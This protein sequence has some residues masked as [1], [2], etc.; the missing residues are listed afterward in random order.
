M[1]NK[2]LILILILSLLVTAC[3]SA[4]QAATATQE[5]I[6]TVIADDTIIA[7]GRVEPLQYAEIAFSTSGVVS[8]VLVKTGEQVKKGQPLIRLGDESETNYAAAQLELVTAQQ[9]LNDLLN[10]SSSDLAQIVIDLK[11]AQE[12]YDK[13]DDYLHYLQDSKK[14]PQTETRTYLI[15]TWKGYEYR[16]KTKSFKGPA[17]QDWIIEAENDLALKKARLV[18]VQRAYDRTKDGADADQLALLEAELN[19]ANAQV[20]AFSV[21][22]PFDGVVADLNAKVGGSINAGEIAV[23]VA[24]FSNWLVKTTDLTE[25]DVVELTEAQLVVVT[26]DAIPD[27]RL[28]GTVLSIGQR[29]TE[30]QGDVVYEVTVLLTDT[31][32]AMRWGMTSE[33]KFERGAQG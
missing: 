26:L 24:D 11:D 2:I 10:S 23:T 4:G 30:N 14:V 33:V 20:A 29:Y 5:A 16:Y 9:A 8:E 22:A 27:V 17:P 19:A 15:Q 7:E 25:I 32:P 6:P 1:K 28:N 3:A 31:N 13:A 12:A 21:M 18:E